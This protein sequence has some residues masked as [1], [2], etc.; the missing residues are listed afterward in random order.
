[1]PRPP[2]VGLLYLEYDYRGVQGGIDDQTALGYATRSARVTG[3]TF[4][5]AKAGKLT[6]ALE[7]A[8]EEAIDSLKKHGDLIGISGNC[9]FMMYYQN[10]VR[11]L[12]KGTPCFM[13][14]LMQAQLISSALP[15]SG[16]ILV[17]TADTGSLTAARQVLL[18]QAGVKVDDPEQFV[19]VGLEELPGFEVVADPS[20]GAMN[21]PLVEAGILELVRSNLRRSNIR[22]ILFECTELPAFADAVR[23]ATG[24]P[25][26]DV[27]TCLSFFHGAVKTSYRAAMLEQQASCERAAADATAAVAVLPVARNTT[28]TLRD[29]ARALGRTQ[30]EIAL[31]AVN[32]LER[33]LL[34]D[35]LEAEVNAITASNV[36]AA[37]WARL[38]VLARAVPAL[39]GATTTDTLNE[40]P[41]A[42]QWCTPSLTVV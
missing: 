19:I 26:F 23:K 6:P 37:V 42:S 17:L 14:P 4:E 39:R 3:L 12:A 5:K 36:G 21:K 20:K 16:Q 32:Y 9:G 25:V 35:P 1:M 30:L 2:V 27:V 29:D 33:E 24:L 38:Q 41:P 18:T 15:T 13:S 28:G 7:I 31:S 11:K 22:A 10:L 8:F 40:V 34:V